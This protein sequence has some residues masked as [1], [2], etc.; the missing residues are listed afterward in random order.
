MSCAWLESF[1]VV[2][3]RTES[4]SYS[5]VPLAFIWFCTSHRQPFPP[6]NQLCTSGAPHKECPGKCGNKCNENVVIPALE[7][8]RFM[9]K[10]YSKKCDSEDDKVLLV[11]TYEFQVPGS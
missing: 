1:G 3:P 8:V 10:M 4:R 11:L 9:P 7:Y 5:P 2:A 6:V